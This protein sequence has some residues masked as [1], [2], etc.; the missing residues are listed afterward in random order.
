M[1]SVYSLK[2]QISLRCYLTQR[3]GVL[4]SHPALVAATED[5]DCSQI[6]KYLGEGLP[7]NPCFPDNRN[8]HPAC[9]E[10]NGKDPTLLLGTFPGADQVCL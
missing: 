7:E 2:G 4:T 3:T 5:L 6:R 10:G 9:G 8:S 1:C